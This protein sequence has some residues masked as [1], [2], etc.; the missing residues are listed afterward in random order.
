M[1][2]DEILKVYDIESERL[3]IRSK[4]HRNR[5]EGRE[6]GLIEGRKENVVSF[7]KTF[8]KFFY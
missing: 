4:M 8:K 5:E 3:L 2:D 1:V 7:E 6:E